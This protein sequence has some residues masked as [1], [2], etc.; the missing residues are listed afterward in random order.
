VVRGWLKA[1]VPPT[2]DP[3][4]YELELKLAS[5]NEPDG[6]SM[7]LPIGQFQVEGWPRSFEPPTPQLEVEASFNGQARLVGLD[8]SPPQLALQPGETV[9]IRLY[10]QAEAEFE[11][12]YTAFIHLIGPDGALYGQLDH[13]PGTGAYPTTGWLPGEYLTDD[14]AIPLASNAPPG[15][16]HLAIG[17]Y[18][19]ESGQRLTLSEAACPGDTC[20]PGDDVVKI[21]GLVVK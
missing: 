1:R 21:P 11:Q 15:D 2:L 4:Q 20:Q 5:A 3:G 13:I 17:L 9:T 10:W 12:N 16:Y 7:T 6:E 14:Y 19:T 8:A 18:Q